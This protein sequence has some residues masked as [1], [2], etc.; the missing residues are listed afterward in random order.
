[1]KLIGQIVAMVLITAMLQAEDDPHAVAYLESAFELRQ[2][3]AAGLIDNV[4]H[5]D[6][7]SSFILEYMENETKL[8]KLMKDSSPEMKARITLSWLNLTRAQIYDRPKDEFKAVSKDEILADNQQKRKLLMKY[9]ES[10][11]K[12]KVE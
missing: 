12:D 10:L 11:S 2:Q 9:I 5:D 7:G 1:M 3:W 4:S 6:S 8:L